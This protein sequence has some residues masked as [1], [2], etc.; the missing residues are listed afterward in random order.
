[1]EAELHAYAWIQNA[2][3]ATKSQVEKQEK[4]QR[5][6]S[7]LGSVASKQLKTPALIHKLILCFGQQIIILSSGTSP[8]TAQ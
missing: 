8:P 3:S 2:R 1:M 5:P 6:S 4:L 7:Y